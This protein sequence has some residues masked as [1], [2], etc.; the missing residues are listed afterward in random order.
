MRFVF[1]HGTGVRRE[2]FDQ[3]VALVASGLGARLSDAD[4]VPCYWGDAFGASLGAGGASIPG[5]DA[6]RG[7]AATGSPL[8][9]ETA[10]WQ[11]LVTDPL[12]ELRVLAETA[13]ADDDGLRMPGVRAAGAEIADALAQLKDAPSLNEEISSLLDSTGIAAAFSEALRAVDSS[14]E[15]LGACEMTSRA[16]AVRELVATTARSVVAQSLSVAGDEALC[17]GAERDRLVDLVGARLGGTG[18]FPGG[19]PAAVLGKLALRLTTQ[20]ALNRWRASLTTRSVPALG[21]ILRYQARGQALRNHLKDV[22]TAS[23]EPTVVIGHSLGGI[24]L[25][26][27]CALTAVDGRP[28]P[29]AYLL[30]TVGSQAPFLH[31]LGALTGLQPTAG[32]PLHF[33]R[34]LN[35]FDRTD[36]LAYRAQPIF[37]DDLRVIDHEVSSRQPFPL[38]HSAYWKLD[39]VYDRIVEEVEKLQ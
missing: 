25:V 12:C 35:I 26:D 9:R 5:K 19:R 21:D 39:A 27:L 22:I 13:A 34:W 8:D 29:G 10:E 28:L 16:P 7:M 18:R 3:L 38:S 32:L 2:R 31:E 20:P 17:T 24:A 14:A 37:P 15:F 11:L 36:L 4:V 30:V 33:P 6:V 23:S 1:V